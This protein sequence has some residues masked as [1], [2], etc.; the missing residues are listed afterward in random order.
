M[1]RLGE[2][3]EQFFL[4]GSRDPRSVI[5]NGD[6]HPAWLDRD[7]HVNSLVGGLGGVLACVVDQVE[8]D[9][10]DGG[11]IRQNRYVPICFSELYVQLHPRLRRSIIEPRM[12][13][14][15]QRRKR[16][17]LTPFT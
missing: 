4:S 3:P 8:E 14:V 16:N 13:W 1:D 12:T 11:G 17:L 15:E 2:W 7:L 10:F 5:M 9:L 6:S